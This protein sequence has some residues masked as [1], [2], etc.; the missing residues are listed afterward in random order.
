M[1]KYVM[2]KLEDMKTRVLE[3]EPDEYSADIVM[4]LVNKPT[5]GDKND[6]Q[7]EVV[8]QLDDG[9]SNSFDKLSV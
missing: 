1:E 4:R 2:L 6:H 5:D 3:W 8:E 9:L 7:V